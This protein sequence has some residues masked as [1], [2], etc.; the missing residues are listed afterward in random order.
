MTY[1]DFKNHLTAEMKYEE[2]V[3]TF[4]KPVNDI[5]SGIHIYVYKLKDLTEVW[6][7]YAAVIMYAKHIDGNQNELHVLI[8]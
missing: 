6:I 4:G 3:T 2:I 7:G 1:D 8:A 5:G